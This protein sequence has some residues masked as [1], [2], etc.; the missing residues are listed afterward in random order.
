MANK[1]ISAAL[2]FTRCGLRNAL[3]FIALLASLGVAYAVTSTGNTSPPAPEGKPA[4][5]VAPR[6]EADLKG[7]AASDDVRRVANWIMRSNT[8]KDHP[9]IIAD[10]AGGLLFAFDANGGLLAKSPALFGAMRSDVLTEEQ[11][12]KSLD[13]T[14][15]ADKITPAGVFAATGYLSA[16]YGESVRFAGF[17]H[18]N[19]LIHRA[20]N[21]TRL[22]RL[23][24]QTVRDN[25]ITYGCINALPEFVDNVLLPN[26]SGESTVVVLPEMQSAASLFSIVDAADPAAQTD[27]V[28]AGESFVRPF[29]WQTGDT[30]SAA[31]SVLQ[32]PARMP[33]KRNDENINS[34]A[35]IAEL[36]VGLKRKI[37]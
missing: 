9:F 8:H 33:R 2:Q 23:L 27:A 14:M 3:P 24:T 25:R 20:P 1:S 6:V 17:A 18:T 26:F 29:L 28:A 31:V 32:E 15:E 21:E 11:A 12:G 36:K 16:S 19:L 30:A 34:P 37:A 35:A 10:K 22:K 4:A 5:P 7:V 13:E